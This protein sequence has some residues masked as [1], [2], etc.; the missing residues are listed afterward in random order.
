MALTA[1][2]FELVN[3]SLANKEIDFDSDTIKC[4]LLSAYTPDASATGHQY[5]SQVKAAGTE[6]VGTGYTAGGVT[7]TSV[8]WTQ[9]GGV[10][11][12]K[13]TIPAWNTTGGSLAAAYAV[14]YDGTPATDATRPVICYW[15]L[16]GAGG[17]QTSSNGTFTLT[18]NA[19]GIFT[20]D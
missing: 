18:Q 17:T 19:S 9:T 15:N 8:T 16:D 12:L 11:A 7:L 4:A 3:K 5:W 20:L 2:K 1:V 6:A 13:G 10:W 14:F